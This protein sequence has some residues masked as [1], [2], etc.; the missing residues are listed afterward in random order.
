[1]GFALALELRHPPMGSAEW[2]AVMVRYR[3]D[4]EVA[5]PNLPPHGAP[6]PANE[7]PLLPTL[8]W[9]L[10]VMGAVVILTLLAQEPG[11][12]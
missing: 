8:F 6:P 10:V 3:G 5:G 11:I 12:W 4:D 9:F 1:M 7:P 2:G